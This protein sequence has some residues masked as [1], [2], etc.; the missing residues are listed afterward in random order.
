MDDV[1]DPW[2]RIVQ[3]PAVARS[4]GAQITRKGHLAEQ[5]QPFSTQPKKKLAIPFEPANFRLNRSGG[6]GSE[7]A[8][9]PRADAVDLV[10][11]T[12][13]GTDMIRFSAVV[14][15]GAFQT[16]IAFSAFRHPA[17][18]ARFKGGIRHN[19]GAGAV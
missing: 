19:V 15:F 16:G 12:F 6:S 10:V 3:S 2:R 8:A 17:G 13:H 18:R 7:R 14:A 4:R 5:L 11:A 9:Q 1:F